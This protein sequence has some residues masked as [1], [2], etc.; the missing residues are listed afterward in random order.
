MADLWLCECPRHGSA[1]QFIDTV[2]SVR[3]YLCSGTSA[4]LCAL[5]PLCRQAGGG[6]FVQ[7]V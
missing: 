3:V 2:V 4:L 7:L 6:E 1:L 5:V